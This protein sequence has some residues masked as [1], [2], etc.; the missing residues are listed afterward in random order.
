MSVDIFYFTGTGNSLFVARQLSAE[1]YD[2]VRILPIKNFIDNKKVKIN[3]D[4]LIIVCP[5]YFRTLPHIVKLFLNKLEFETTSIHTYGVVTCNGEPG[6]SLFT[7]DRILK[8]KGQSLRAGFTVVMPG[9]S[10]IV[11]DFTNTAEIRTQRLE[12]SY[13]KIN[14]ISDYLNNK[15]FGR[16]EGNDSFKYHL[17]GIITG[18]V[19]RYIYKTPTKFRT[20]EGCTKCRTCVKACPLSNIKLGKEG[21]KWGSN[22]EHCLACFHWCPSMA[23]EI[24]NSTVGK[25]RYHHPEI[26]IKD[27][28]KD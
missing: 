21:V 4:C 12:E 11:R 22:C 25:L 15:R 16:I 9:N 1:L 28:Y 5:V 2:E 27:M 13:N 26:S 6:H 19:A 18:V 3:S 7:M 14:E 20:T 10:L 17:K 24:G 23:V 8:R